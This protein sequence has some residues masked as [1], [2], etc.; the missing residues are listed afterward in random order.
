MLN[1]QQKHLHDG[2]LKKMLR[3]P[4]NNCQIMNSI[5]NDTLQARFQ[6]QTIVKCSIIMMFSRHLEHAKPATFSHTIQ[7]Q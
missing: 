4:F 2:L 6:Q 3:I 1:F 5:S 7:V